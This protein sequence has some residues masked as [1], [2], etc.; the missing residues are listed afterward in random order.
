MHNEFF[1]PELEYQGSRATGAFILTASHNPG[2]PNE[3]TR[4]CFLFGLG[5]WFTVAIRAPLSFLCFG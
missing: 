1:T 3:V 5:L 2:G 4:N